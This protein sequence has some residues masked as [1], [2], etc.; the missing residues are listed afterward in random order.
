MPI[1]AKNTVEKFLPEILEIEAKA[2]LSDVLAVSQ[3][4]MCFPD[5]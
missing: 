4:T 2:L 1:A 3:L 5:A